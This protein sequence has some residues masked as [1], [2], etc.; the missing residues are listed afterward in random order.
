MME[1]LTRLEESREIPREGD[2]ERLRYLNELQ[3]I[4]SGP[5]QVARPLSRG[6]FT[7]RMQARAPITPHHIQISLLLSSS[8]HPETL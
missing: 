8:C 6:L 5:D 7:L 3:G 2:S 1:R 4:Q